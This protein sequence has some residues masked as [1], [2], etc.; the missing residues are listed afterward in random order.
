MNKKQK[1]MLIRIIVAAVLMVILYFISGPA[2]CPL[3]IIPDP[4]SD[5]RV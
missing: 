4:L 5:R 1:K 2:L 3:Y